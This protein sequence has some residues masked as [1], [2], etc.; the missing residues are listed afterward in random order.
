MREN[1][2]QITDRE[3]EILRLISEGSSDREIAQNLYLSIN[4][5]K[6][7]N[8]QIYAKLG[9]SS[10]TAAVA[11]AS[12]TGLIEDQSE[13]LRPPGIKTRDNLPLKL[14]S[15]VGREQEIAD[16]KSLLE[17][18][19]LL[20]LTGP[21]G[22]GKTR[23]AL[24][25]GNHLLAENCFDGIY[26]VELAPIKNP[27]QVTETI[28]NALNLVATVDDTGPDL[29]EKFLKDKNILLLIDNFEH[30]LAAAPQI[31]DLLS[32]A[33]NLKVLCTSREALNLSGEQI[34][35]VSPL[36][37]PDLADKN[38]LRALG[39]YESIDLFI[40]RAKEVKPD[41]NPTKDDL[42]IVAEIC[43]K[44]DGLPLVIELAAVRLKIFTLSVL[45]RHLKDKFTIL[46]AVSRDF[47]ARHQ[48]LYRVID[49]SY[50]LL[51]NDE[52][53][54]FSRLA[55]FRGGFTIEAADLVGCHD[56]SLDVLDGLSSLVDKSL[57]RQTEGQNGSQ[58][59]NMLE[60]ILEYAREKLKESNQQE[61]IILRHARYFTELS[62]R[63]KQSTRGGPDQMDWLLKLEADHDNLRAVYDWALNG[64]DI[65]LGL[66]L[67]G[68]L[69]YFWLKM[70]HIFEGKEW[71]KHALDLMHDA[72]LDVQASVY[73]SAAVTCYWSGDLAKSK[74]MC[75]EALKLYQGL[76]D[77]QEIGWMHTYLMYLSHGIPDQDQELRENFEKAVAFLEDSDDKLGLCQA[78]TFLGVHEKDIGNLSDARIALDKSSTIAREIGDSNREVV[79]L[80]HR[81]YI[82]LDEGD[83]DTATEMFLNSLQLELSI[84][85]DQAMLS[86]TLMGLAET[87]LALEQPERALVLLGAAEGL[88]TSR[89][90]LLPDDVLMF[91]KLLASALDQ[92]DEISCEQARKQGRDLNFEQIV[93]YALGNND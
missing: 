53:L 85:H 5:V 14:S 76:E 2:S 82:C 10:R 26:F 11:A 31:R 41:F 34:F 62:E 4:T 73:A 75:T 83:P 54:L 68:A 32:E 48:T 61:Q 19:R 27:Q 20:T 70:Y 28:L 74:M 39:D 67:V 86:G 89:E 72:P 44:L 25:V 49:W 52:K 81:G 12:R 64:G 45:L 43:Q 47:P 17:S 50:D 87:A 29:I 92:L 90:R 56:L 60:T 13:N 93:A 16:I 59:F 79:N 22:V 42:L 65:N 80:Y 23:L 55:V 51:S 66:R 84:L 8:R 7:H 71:T 63:G 40:Q 24:Q 46:K 15:F 37:L 6:W 57:L 3:L 1:M 58:R 77:Q 18:N 30:V 33:S 88:Y 21:G 9:V 69:D 35:P 78:Y 91:Q 38:S 36:N